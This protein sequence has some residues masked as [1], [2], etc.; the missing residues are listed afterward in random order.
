VEIR[1]KKE[2]LEILADFCND[3]AKGLML[4]GLLGQAFTERGSVYLKVV[5]PGL[6]IIFSV[7]FLYSAILIKRK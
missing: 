2:Q 7:I 1:L 3:V 4:A 5:G 6:S